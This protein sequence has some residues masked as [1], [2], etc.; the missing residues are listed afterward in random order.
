MPVRE[1]VPILIKRHVNATLDKLTRDCAT[2]PVL[3]F[4]NPLGHFC[5]DQ[6]LDGQGKQGG[7]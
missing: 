2:A 6:L 1:S 4:F 5:N 3:N 7:F